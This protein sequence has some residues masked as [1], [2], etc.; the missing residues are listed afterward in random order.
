MYK[1]IIFVYFTITFEH[2]KLSWCP[3]VGPRSTVIN[4]PG[5]VEFQQQQGIGLP[6]LMPSVSQ[7]RI[8]LSVQAG[9]IYLSFGFCVT[10]LQCLGTINS[11]IK[12]F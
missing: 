10:E 12:L 9:I 3:D 4:L 5:S 8:P 1:K 7:G 11:S 6:C 2:F